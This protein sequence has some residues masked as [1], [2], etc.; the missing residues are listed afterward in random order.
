[1]RSFVPRIFIGYSVVQ[2]L[3]SRLR[4]ARQAYPDAGVTN[5]DRARG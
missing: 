4:A 2:A 1:L 5:P 3:R